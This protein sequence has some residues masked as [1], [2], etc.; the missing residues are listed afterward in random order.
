[1]VGLIEVL[2]G[3]Q[4]VGPCL[5]ERSDRVPQ[6]DP[7][8]GIETGRRLVEQQQPGSSDQ[9]RAEVQPPAHPAGIRASQPVA[10]LDEPEL[11]EHRGGAAFARRAGSGRTG[12]RPSRGS[13]GRSSR[14]RRPRTGPPGR[15]PGGPRRVLARVVAG[16]EQRARRRRAAVSPP[17]RTNVVLPA[18]L[19][20]STAVTCPGSAIRSRPS[21]AVVFPYCLVRPWASIVAVISVLLVR[22][23]LVGVN[24]AP[25]AR[26]RSGRLSSRRAGVARDTHAGSVVVQ[27]GDSLPSDDVVELG[28][29]LLLLGGRFAMPVNSR[30]AGSAHIRD[31]ASRGPQFRGPA[32]RGSAC[33]WLRSVAMGERELEEWEVRWSAASANWASLTPARG[34]PPRG[35]RSARRT[36]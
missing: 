22:W 27:V 14:A 24:A 34:R 36:G 30:S 9:T 31:V 3:Q 20:P 4:H 19:G 23:S 11:L 7:A 29:H 6:L 8:A 13:R 26:I 18:P 16:D 21:R 1:M 17:S 12:G 32:G 33:K 35:E 5:H 2:R 10:G 15:S 28:V 25:G